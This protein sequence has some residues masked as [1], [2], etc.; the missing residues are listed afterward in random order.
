[1]K[2]AFCF[3][4]LGDLTQPLLWHQFFEH[5]QNDQIVCHPKHPESVETDF[6][7]SGIIDER[8]VTAHG[9]VSLV[10]ATL[11]LLRAAYQQGD[12]QYFL[13]LSESTIPL[14]SR[15]AIAN[16]LARCRGRSIIPYRIPAPLSEHARRQQALPVGHG[17]DPFYVHDQ[18]VILSRRHVERLLDKPGLAWFAG[19]FAPDEHYFLNVLVH[20]CGV[21]VGEFINQRKTFVNWEQREVCERRDATGALIQ[22]TIHPKTYH[23]LTGAEL[24]MARRQGC[25][26]FRKVSAQCDCSRF[27]R[28][29]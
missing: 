7:R 15:R 18:W 1:M 8:V 19:M 12:S 25:W 23:A 16:E 3:L 9:T 13:L 20:A 2:L 4:T 11:N 28:A 29:A 6:L 21:S 27:S 22:R 24:A 14:V 26:F 17:F 10:E 5:S